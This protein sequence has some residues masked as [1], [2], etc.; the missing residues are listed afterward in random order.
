MFDSDFRYEIGKT[1]SCEDFNTYSRMAVCAPGIHYFEYPVFAILYML[2][3]EEGFV[4]AVREGEIDDR[5][6]KEYL[7]EGFN[8]LKRRR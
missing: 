3:R 6:A 8:T 4:D 5:V 7:T 1:V 2:E